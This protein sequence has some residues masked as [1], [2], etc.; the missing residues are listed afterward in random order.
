MEQNENNDYNY[1]NIFLFD[2]INNKEQFIFNKF[3]Y[4]P[5]K[6]QKLKY[7]KINLNTFSFVIQYGKYFGF[8]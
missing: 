1:V 8:I 7:L 5:Q 3:I 2:I 4:L 6:I